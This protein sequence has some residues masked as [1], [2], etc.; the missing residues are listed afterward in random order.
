[1]GEDDPSLHIQ[2]ARQPFHFRLIVLLDGNC[3]DH[4]EP[5]IRPL[6]RQDP[7]GSNKKVDA[8]AGYKPPDA[9]NNRRTF[10]NP[11]LAVDGS[12]ACASFEFSGYDDSITDHFDFLFRYALLNQPRPAGD[13]IG[14]DAIRQT[15]C[16]FQS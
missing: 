6:V 10:G 8:L 9:C 2:V 12:T 14:Q 4:Q 1:P 7:C 11:E 13:A 15:T 5:N 3:P 16:N